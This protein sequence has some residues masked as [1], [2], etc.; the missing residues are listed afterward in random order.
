MKTF[1]PKRTSAWVDDIVEMEKATSAAR[2]RA[3]GLF[4]IFIVDLLT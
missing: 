4:L 3:L 2:A 1:L